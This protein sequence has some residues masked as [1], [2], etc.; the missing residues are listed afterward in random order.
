MSGRHVFDIQPKH[1]IATMYCF[2]PAG[3]SFL[4]L[5]SIGLHIGVAA[6][7][8]ES[9]CPRIS[10]VFLMYISKHSAVN[11]SVLKHLHANVIQIGAFREPFEPSAV[12]SV[13]QLF[14]YP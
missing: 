12:K 13:V 2:T 8:L 4:E 5:P 7:V 1:P 14:V 10:S 6:V 3:L 9:I 11:F